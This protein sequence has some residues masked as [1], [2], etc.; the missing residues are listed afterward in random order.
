M[1]QQKPLGR[2]PRPVL[3]RLRDNLTFT[4]DGC[5]EYASHSRRGRSYR[6]IQLV[7]NGERVLRYAHRV[8]YEL[9]VAPIPDGLQLDHLCRNR[10]CVNP[11]H[12]EPVSPKEN[13]RRARALIT[14]CPS[15]HA[16]DAENTAFSPDGRRYCRAC[17]RVKALARY[18]KNKKA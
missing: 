12:L 18:H 15:G 13:T 1:K 4:A 8:V 17:K 14:E 3:E 6:Q 2:P 5:W 9:M 16:Y 11:Q 10:M 7:Q